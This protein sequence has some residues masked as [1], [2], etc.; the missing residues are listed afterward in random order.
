MTDEHVFSCTNQESSIYFESKANGPSANANHPNSKVSPVNAVSELLLDE[1]SASGMN[2]LSSKK[3]SSFAGCHLENGS[4]LRNEH[5]SGSAKQ[6]VSNKG[7]LPNTKK[8]SKDSI[9]NTELKV[10][11]DSRIP[12]ALR[13][14]TPSSEEHTALEICPSTLNL[15][16]F[17][18]RTPVQ[19]VRLKKYKTKIV[20]YESKKAVKVSAPNTRRFTPLNKAALTCLMHQRKSCNNFGN[21]KQKLVVKDSKV[22]SAKDLIRNLYKQKKH[23]LKDDKLRIT[24]ANSFR[25]VSKPANTVKSSKG[26]SKSPGDAL[27]NGLYFNCAMLN[28]GY[29]NASR[30][31]TSAS[32]KRP[33]Y[34]DSMRARASPDN[35]LKAVSTLCNFKQT[36]KA[37]KLPFNIYAK[38]L[39]P[40]I[41]SMRQSRSCNKGNRHQMKQRPIAEQILPIKMSGID[42][43]ETPLFQKMLQGQDC[44]YNLEEDLLAEIEVDSLATFVRKSQ[45]NTSKSSMQKHSSRIYKTLHYLHNEILASNP[46]TSLSL[47][48]ALRQCKELLRIRSRLLVIF[49]IIIERD[50]INYCDG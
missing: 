16:L 1:N 43:A 31:Q 19:L 48:D 12:H 21:L 38:Q 8:S 18:A 42:W 37:G 15:S 47:M 23:I 33:P 9:S 11:P 5:S 45:G 13:Q 46:P 40:H 24:V 7:W 2:A 4:F 50:V 22:L 6:S 36:P 10:A 32:N 17:P 41:T 26:P 30:C 20:K 29:R 34:F 39:K 3:S 35:E 27:R 49:I 14:S 44:L 25:L 28:G